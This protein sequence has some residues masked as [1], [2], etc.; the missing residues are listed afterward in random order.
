MSPVQT[1]TS[2]IQTQTEVVA[3]QRETIGKHGKSL[4]GGSSISAENSCFFSGG[5]QS[6]SSAFR[7]DPTVNHTENSENFQTGILLPR[8]SNFPRFTAGSGDFSASFRTVPAVSGD[9]NDRPGDVTNANTDVADTSTDV[10]D[11]NKDV[12][13]PNTDVTDPNKDVTDPNTE[14]YGF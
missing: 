11:T 14:D 13:D 1:K 3:V 5:F 12:T 9:R 10:T 7:Q 8:S 4:E 2:P 6:T